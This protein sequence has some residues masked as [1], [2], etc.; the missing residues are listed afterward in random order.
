MLQRLEGTNWV[1]WTSLCPIMMEELLCICVSD[2]FEINAKLIPSNH[3]FNSFLF[4]LAAAEG[5]LECVQFLLEQCGVPYDPK[6]RWGNMP[7]DEA[8]TFGHEEVVEY[9]RSWHDRMDSKNGDDD[10]SDN[11]HLNHDEKDDI[12]RRTPSTD[13]LYDK[14]DSSSPIPQPDR[15]DKII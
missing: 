13:S 15:N 3:F 5:H 9:L 14:S 2:W 7:I 12:L 10:D 1:V 6:D 4:I 8:E 11:T